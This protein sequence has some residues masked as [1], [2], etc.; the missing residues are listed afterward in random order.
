MKN[1]GF[2]LGLR[3]A[4]ETIPRWESILSG[5]P[6]TRQN[7]QRANTAPTVPTA[8]RLI[9]LPIA[10]R[11][12]R[13]ASRT[14]LRAA[15]HQVAKE[16]LLCFAIIAAQKEIQSIPGRGLTFSGVEKLWCNPQTKQAML[17]VTQRILDQ[18][19][20]FE[21]QYSHKPPLLI[22]KPLTKREVGCHL[23]VPVTPDVQV[24]HVTPQ[25]PLHSWAGCVHYRLVHPTRGGPPGATS[26]AILCPGSTA[27][28]VRQYW[29]VAREAAARA[30]LQAL[31][32]NDTHAF[33]EHVS[34]LKVSTLL[35]IMERTHAFM[36]RIGLSIKTKAEG[37]T[38]DCSAATGVGNGNSPLQEL[39][40]SS[41]EY[42]RFK[43]Y[44]ASTKDEYRLAHR[45]EVVVER[46]P[47]GLRATLF[48]VQLEGLRF[49]YSL[50]AN[51][52]NGIL[53]DEMGVGKTVQTL[54]FL[55]HLKNLP[56][57]PEEGGGPAKPQR[58][59]HLILAPLSVVREWREACHTFTPDSLTVAAYQELNDPICEAQ[60]YDLVLLP[61]HAVR[62]VRSKAAQIPWGYI[63]VDEAHK[64][65]G[66]LGT[67]TARAILSLPYQRRLVLTG[68]PLN[69][70]L[71]ELWSL[72][73]FLNPDVFSDEDS[74]DDVF[75]RPFATYETKEMDLSSEERG[76][77]VLRLH[78]IL[79]P[80]ML[81]RTKKDVDRSLRITHHN[82]LCPVTAMQVALLDLLRTQRRTP[83]VATGWGNCSTSSAS[84]SSPEEDIPTVD[85]TP[86]LGRRK[87]LTLTSENVSE[88]TAQ[89]LCNH[90][91]LI[92]FCSQVL[93]HRGL[94]ETKSAT[95]LGGA[96]E[97]VLACSGK[98]LV[99][100]LLLSRLIVAKKKA[101]IFTHW[102]D[103]IDLLREYVAGQG[104]SHHLEV[105]SGSTS[106]GERR[107][108][109][110]RFREDDVCLF[111]VLSI[112]AGG[113]GINLQ[114]A[115]MVILLDRDYTTTNEDQALA[116]V[117]RVGQRFTVRALYFSTND[118]AE[119][120]IGLLANIKN[121]PRQ[122]IIEEGTYHPGDS[123]D[124]EVHSPNQA[125]SPPD[126]LY[127]AD[128]VAP[129]P[130]MEAAT[131]RLDI[132]G[133]LWSLMKKM[134]AMPVDVKCDCPHGF[135]PSVSSEMWA[136][137]RTAVVSLD[138]LVL[139]EA[140][141][142]PNS[143]ARR[144]LQQHLP[145][146]DAEEYARI[147]SLPLSD[148]PDV[149]APQVF[150]G[151]S[152]NTR[153]AENWT[154]FWCLMSDA[155]WGP[156]LLMRCLEQSVAN[157]RQQRDPEFL[158][159]KR[160]QRARRAMRRLKRACADP[161]DAFWVACWEK[162]MSADDD[163]IELWTRQQ[164]QRRQKA[165]EEDA[166]T[167]TTLCTAVATGKDSSS[168]RTE[169]V[170]ASSWTA[171]GGPR[172]QPKKR[173]CSLSGTT[174]KS[175]PRGAGEKTAPPAAL[176]L[177]SLTN[178][179]SEQKGGSCHLNSEETKSGL[180]QTSAGC[181]D[182]AANRRHLK[183]ERGAAF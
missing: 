28:D 169:M 91:F 56:G 160:E 114:S 70:D 50:Y 145:P 66:N 116:R 147:C 136:A 43:A 57:T 68:T 128:S 53:A 12:E 183:R 77:L 7:E 88:S 113:C 73:Y 96:A 24:P 142:D 98:F 106:E 3:E 17:A 125:A 164:A 44:V 62:N 89:L 59:P 16:T 15:F 109:V 149:S 78:Q 133:Q 94:S 179:A 153:N 20:K 150:E 26:R 13:K 159:A 36:Q 165:G 123:R 92:P 1:G 174:V 155:R 35:Q 69:S 4:I 42:Q 173:G 118:P 137:L 111:F 11:E 126:G 19:A 161:P 38:N 130:T 48:P 84:T 175:R 156:A 54:S 67:L 75:R 166:P 65:L 80:F 170:A 25:V 140:D 83:C 102:L 157:D 180:S 14:D 90:A 162:G 104:W 60:L 168:E 110:Q 87:Q 61:I 122:A 146:A 143:E 32:R 34:L 5:N 18:A 82:L 10:N 37:G 51:G 71:Q 108:S 101:V 152:I 97:T 151:A 55:L 158:R 124:E 39:L 117:Y 79:R 172:T 76:L 144:A 29:K 139:T 163:I 95:E 99:L 177:D 41:S 8:V 30:R 135:L 40:R 45:K 21:Q 52:I 47:D 85:T 119:S 49:L 100:H 127:A 120:R 178:Q 64:A 121:K 86:I 148:P 132:M 112:K 31:R 131:H 115:H 141:T 2:H 23:H 74:F 176:T 72:L 182:S 27:A 107:R 9:S 93:Y 154:A 138:E 129:P 181:D 171:S 105:L 33:A 167:P 58:R 134:A 22:N 103:C 46:Q 81:R 63:V 6:N